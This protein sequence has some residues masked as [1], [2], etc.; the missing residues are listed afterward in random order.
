MQYYRNKT[1]EAVGI[2]ITAIRSVKESVEEVNIQA[3]VDV[4]KIIVWNDN[5]KLA[6]A[7]T[8]VE[9][10]RGWLD[11]CRKEKDN[12]A[13]EGQIHFETKLFETRMKYETKLVS[14]KVEALNTI[15]K[16]TKCESQQ[17]IRA[18]LRS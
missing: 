16:S 3:E 14:A 13:R 10:L 5:K 11:K 4:P 15:P 1:Q 8:A 2:H 12:I 17:N 7:D 6:E 18:K 9:E